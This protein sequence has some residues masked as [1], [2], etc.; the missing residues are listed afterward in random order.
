MLVVALL[1]C[2]VARAQWT[3]SGPPLPAATTPT[4]RESGL[5]LDHVEAFDAVTD[6][7]GSLWLA[8]ARTAS[9]PHVGLWAWTGGSL[10][11]RRRWPLPLDTVKD[12]RV[13]LAVSDDGDLMVGWA[14]P[15]EVLWVE[16]LSGVPERRALP[17][18][19]EPIAAFAVAAQSHV[20]SLLVA[21]KLHDGHSLDPF[22]GAWVSAVDDPTWHRIGKGE[23]VA[24]VRAFGR[25]AWTLIDYRGRHDLVL[26]AAATWPATK[27]HRRSRCVRP[28]RVPRRRGWGWR[29][30]GCRS[31][32]RASQ[33]MGGPDLEGRPSVR[34]AGAHSGDEFN[35]LVIV[36]DGK[37]V[38]APPGRTDL[39]VPFTAGRDTLRLVPGDPPRLVFVQEG[40]LH[41]AR[42]TGETWW[43]LGRVPKVA[44]GIG[45]PELQS[46]DPW[47]SNSPSG[48][49]LRWIEYSEHVG[50]TLM[51]ADLFVGSGTGPAREVPPP[52]LAASANRWLGQTHP[53]ESFL[54]EEVPDGK[55]DRLW[56]ASGVVRRAAVV[57]DGRIEALPAFEHAWAYLVAVGQMDDGG[58]VAVGGATNVWRS[59]DAIPV[60]FAYRLEGGSWSELGP[61]EGDPKS[62]GYVTTD[63]PLIVL[64]TPVDEVD[65]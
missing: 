21:Q 50:L 48:P 25:V 24:T 60:W 6:P 57:R 47:F 22:L 44:P 58:V 46:Q 9:R 29:R 16:G 49:L 27:R 53:G 59:S 4:W 1:L 26:R 2:P 64:S 20:R 54:L 55:W 32:G 36:D 8:V 28:I 15:H 12:V 38:L 42:W 7:G 3:W 63:P 62:T 14:T 23:H 34:F 39:A 52:P 18:P 41:A 65:E 40:R 51:E 10:T 35:R 31:R 19:G 61:L 43:G 56:G 45:S 13:S 30:A 17:V 5:P 37:R 33:F 11:E